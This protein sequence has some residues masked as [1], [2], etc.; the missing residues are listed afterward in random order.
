MIWVAKQNSGKVDQIRGGTRLLLP[1]NK[2][3][4][5]K[6]NDFTWL[7][8]L[9]KLIVLVNISFTVN[10]SCLL[11]T[12]TLLTKVCNEDKLAQNP[13]QKLVN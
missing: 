9:V 10:V 12:S 6:F 11:W 4:G 1:S 7:I 3:K 13:P 8:K 5:A 2:F